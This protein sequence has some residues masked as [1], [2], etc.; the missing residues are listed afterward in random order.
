[1]LGASR[2][3]L[4]VTGSVAVEPETEAY[5]R[6]VA[7]AIRIVPAGVVAVIWIITPTGPV[8][9]IAVPVVWIAIAQAVIA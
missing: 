4:V 3:T 7:V 1:M 8:T 9:I 5:R 2:L 6:P